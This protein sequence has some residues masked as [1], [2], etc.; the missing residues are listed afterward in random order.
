M[1]RFINNLTLCDEYRGQPFKTRPWQDA[2]IRPLFGTL[3]PDGLRQYRKCFLFLPRK[4][5][6]TQTTAGVATGVILGTPKQGEWVTVAA[7]DRGQASK[8][9]NKVVEMIEN[10]RYLASKCKIYHSVK[11]IVVKKSGNILEVISA[12][13]RRN[14]GGNPS[15]VIIDELHCQPNRKLFDALSSSFGARLEPLF[16]SITTAGNDFTSLVRDEY[17]YAVGV[18]D[19]TTDDPEYLPVIYEA[20]PE[21][22]WKDER[23]WHK[24]M[25]ALGD[26]APIEFIRSEFKRALKSPAEESKFR[27][28]YLNQWVASHTKWLDRAAWEVCGE[29]TFDPAEL[30]GRECYAGLDLSNTRD[31]TALVLVFPFGDAVRVLCR[32]WIPEVYARERDA[33]GHTKYLEWSRAGLITL[34]QKPVI[35]HDF[36]LDEI[37]ELKS[38]YRIKEIRTDPYYAS[39]IFA[40]LMHENVNMIA[41]R[42]R[43][44]DMTGPVQ[45][46]EIMVAMNL[47]Q[48]NNNAVLNWM[49]GNVVSESDSYGNRKF[50]KAA[51]ADKVDGMVA[52]AM[53]TGAFMVDI[54]PPPPKITY[55]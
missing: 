11:R 50:S 7:S 48:H 23:V 36:I 43:P 18:R 55:G 51:S 44:V 33:K 38:Q 45:Q 27:Q 3:R 22:D 1:V 49:A 32:F 30:R 25:P 31:I 15:H 20:G 46:L 34:T 40:K 41:M 29:Q 21:D 28:F 52:L 10:D 19:G 9:Y 53:A 35:D 47:L 14:H 12:D 16:L 4:Q 17:E 54:P 39:Q 26:F 37:L 24:A 5:A 2:W 6:K 8:L 13:G 42:Q